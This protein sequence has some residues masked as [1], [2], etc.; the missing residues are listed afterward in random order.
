MTDITIEEVMRICEVSKMVA[1][2]EDG[3]I[4]KFVREEQ[5]NEENK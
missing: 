4:K 3:Q 5:T 2:M 1:V